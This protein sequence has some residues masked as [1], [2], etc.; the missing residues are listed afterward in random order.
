MIL[1]SVVSCNKEKQILDTYFGQKPC[2]VRMKGV[3]KMMLIIQE[4]SIVVFI[5]NNMFLFFCSIMT[6]E[7]CHRC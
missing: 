2:R 6:Y 5:G 1:V 7:Y 3:W 4:D